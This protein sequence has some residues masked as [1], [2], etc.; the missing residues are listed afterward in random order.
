MIRFTIYGEPVAQGRPRASTAGGFVR[1]YDPKK[2]RDYKDYVR[3]AAADHAPPELL[4]GPLA[5]M[6]IAY[7]SIPKS[8]SKRKAA[9]AEAGEIF[10]V[11]KPDADNYLKGVKDALKGVM[12]VDDSQVVDAYARKR[13]SIKPRIEVIIRQLGE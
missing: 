9:A 6:V 4:Q 10:P 8:F 7:R 3:L 2:S 1:M 13:Y 12:W 11:S 5:V